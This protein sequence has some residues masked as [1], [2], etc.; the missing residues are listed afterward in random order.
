MS[1]DLRVFV[2]N[3][4]QRLLVA[5][6]FVDFKDKRFALIAN[7][8]DFAGN[9]LGC[10]LRLLSSLALLLCLCMNNSLSRQ[11]QTCE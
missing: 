10:R 6:T 7:G 4:L 9:G 11:K 1:L 2:D 3:E 8:R 5:T